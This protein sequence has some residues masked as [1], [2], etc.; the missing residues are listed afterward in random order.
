MSTFLKTV[1]KHPKKD[2]PLLETLPIARNRWLFVVMGL[3]RGVAHVLAAGCWY[4][5]FF[6][7]C[8]EKHVH[9]RFLRG[10]DKVALFFFGLSK[11]MLISWL[12]GFGIFR[13]LALSRKICSIQ[14]SERFRHP[15]LCFLFREICSFQVRERF[16]I[17]GFLKR[18]EKYADVVA[19]G[20]GIFVFWGCHEKYAY[21]LAFGCLCFG[22]LAR[23]PL[24]MHVCWLHHSQTPVGDIARYSC[25][26]MCKY[27]YTTKQVCRPISYRLAGHTHAREHEKYTNQRKQRRAHS[28]AR[29][30]LAPASRDERRGFAGRGGFIY[31]P[32]Y[33]CQGLP[34]DGFGVYI[35]YSSGKSLN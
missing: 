17:I 28:S 18:I 31:L 23:A 8:L 29:P 6:L 34:S 16:R 7:E 24:R 27:T 1:P 12:V 30:S 4:F 14:I 2:R 35:S 3:S 25:I 11:S 32:I 5:C 22:F 33:I 21:G 13:C 20:F 15:L 10:S 19:C 9:F 26:C